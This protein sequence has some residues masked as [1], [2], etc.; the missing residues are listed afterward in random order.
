MDIRA[1]FKKGL[2]YTEM[3]LKHN[4]DWRTAK[5]YAHSD[6][7]PTYELTESKPSKPDPYK[8]KIDLWFEDAPYSAV[9]VHEKLIEIG[10]DCK[11]T[12][13]CVP[14]PHFAQFFRA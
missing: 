12:I 13:R 8:A 14:K 11:Y 3:G 5:R 10:A 2:S 7:R 6:H 4:M 1:D 9:R